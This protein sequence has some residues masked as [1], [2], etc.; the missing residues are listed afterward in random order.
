VLYIYTRHELDLDLFRSTLCDQ[1]PPTADLLVLYDVQFDNNLRTF[2]LADRPGRCFVGIPD[3]SNGDTTS[4]DDQAVSP[5]LNKFGRHFPISN[6]DDLNQCAVVFV[7][8]KTEENTCGEARL[9]SLLFTFAQQQRDLFVYEVSAG[10]SG[11]LVPV[12]RSVERLLRRR[13]Y[14]VEKTRDAERVGIL[15]GTLGTRDY[16]LMLARLRQTIR[17]AGKRCYT[18]LL[19]KPNVAKLANFPEIDVFVLVACPE[20][21][22]PDTKVSTGTYH[23]AGK[24]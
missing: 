8:T 10:G 15:V 5:S 16:P 12:G 20:S 17:Q 18:F 23:C 9:L 13:Y 2:H 11:S 22:F 4:V 24:F 6:W 21:S 1:F 14:L 3:S 7:S 19:G